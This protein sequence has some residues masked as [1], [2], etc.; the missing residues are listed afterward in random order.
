MRKQALL[1]SFLGIAVAVLLGS[2][3]AYAQLRLIPQAAR[4]VYE[5]LPDLPLENTYT[6]INPNDGGP[7]PEEDTLVRQMMVY[8]LQMAGRSPTNRFD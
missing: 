3:P 7:T 1:P 4:Q 6:P 5:A 2:G 8:H